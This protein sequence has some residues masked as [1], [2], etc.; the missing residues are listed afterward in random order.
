MWHKCH[1]MSYKRIQ[2]PVWN[3]S[4]SVTLTDWF[5][6]GSEIWKYL[7]ACYRNATCFTQEEL[8]VWLLFSVWLDTPHKLWEELTHHWCYPFPLS[9]LVLLW[10]TMLLSGGKKTN[11]LGGVEGI[12]VILFEVKQHLIKWVALT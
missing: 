10:C 8:P 4:T 6:A 9:E 12:L 2:W 5:S 1:H 11:S 3:R 7:C